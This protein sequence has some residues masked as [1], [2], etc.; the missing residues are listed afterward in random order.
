MINPR[1]FDFKTRNEKITVKKSKIKR[2]NVINIYRAMK[3]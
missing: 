2:K 1:Y 3:I